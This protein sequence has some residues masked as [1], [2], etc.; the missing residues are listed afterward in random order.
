M[1]STAKGDKLEDAF[2]DYL[3]DQKDRGELVFGLYPSNRCEIVKR[4]GYPC[5][6]R[7]GK[8]QFD[9]VIELYRDGSQ[10][11]SSYVVFEC[12][13]YQGAI[14]ETRVT[15][16]SDKLNRVFR[17]AVKGVLV[18]SSRLQSGAD[19]I[20]RSRSLGIVKYDA[21]GFEV[22]ADRNGVNCLE[23][24]FVRSQIFQDERS[25]RSL[26]FSAFDD[27]RFFG[28][29]N[30]FLRSLEPEL[31]VAE[32]AEIGKARHSVPFVSDQEI[33][34]MATTILEAVHYRSGPVD[35]KKICSLLRLDLQFSK[36]TT[37]NPDGVVV[38]GSANFD[39]RSIQINLHKD[40]N[41]ERFTIGHEIG[42]F[43][44][45]HDRYLRSETIVEQDLFIDLDTENV[46]NYDR[47]EFQ[48]NAFSSSIVL[49]TRIFRIAVEVGRQKFDIRDRSHGY[50]YVDDQLCNSVT[51]D[52]LLTDL[53]L[54]FEVSKQAIEI[55]L[56]RLGLLNDQRRRNRTA[57]AEHL[58]AGM[59]ASL[60]R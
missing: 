1:N 45:K 32:E 52:E 39:R 10:T 15:D 50:I 29:I 42:H 12:K 23:N 33:E 14:P 28:T 54:Y 8:V 49:P 11:P 41:R 19:A 16:F 9:V 44:L 58:L 22:V 38:L 43:C 34:R 46:L 47:L 48:A 55:K 24:R 2:F 35:L 53:S 60:G 37:L 3:R 18:V 20:A 13:N 4:K 21:T 27:G 7:G 30:Q 26:R 36:K 17:H 59:A 51:Y 25:G 56:K 6:E 5:R 40:R 31:F 57:P